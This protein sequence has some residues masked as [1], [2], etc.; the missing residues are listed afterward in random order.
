[1]DPG[2]FQ[3]RLAD[4][5]ERTALSGAAAILIAPSPDLAYLTGYDPTPLER[6]SLLV[7]RP[8]ERP[9]LLVPM[10][11]R[12]LAAAAPAAGALE[13]IAW[14][15][16]EDPYGRTAALLGDGDILVG[17]RIWGA[18]VLAL[19]AAAPGRTWVS[20]ASVVGAMRARK[21]P[22]ELHALRRAAAAADA[23]LADLLAGRLTGRRETDVAEELATHLVTHGHAS[24]EFTIVA[25][26]PNAA[27]PHH[28]PTD[29][30]LAAGDVLVL[31]FG[32]VL[33]GYYSDT[34]RTVS[35]GVPSER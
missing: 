8:G 29:R 26:G 14:R 11:E 4:A 3:R 25:S 19:Q 7:V 2:R 17:D 32:G 15:D 35:L 18:H 31:D 28:Q 6:P 21:D 20:A 5:A 34:T 30:V 10:L 33:D 9:A 22:D 12:P 23:A 24:A 1:V 16:D 13:L 27:S